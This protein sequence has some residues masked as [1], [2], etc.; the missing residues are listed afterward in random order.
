MRKRKFLTYPLQWHEGM[1]M[2]PQHFQQND[3]L[4]ERLWGYHL[5]HLAPFYWGIHDLKVDPTMLLRSVLR[6]LSFE[7]VMPDGTVLFFPQEVNDTLEISLEDLPKDENGVYEVFLT[8]ADEKESAEGVAMRYKTFEHTVQDLHNENARASISRLRYSLQLHIG[9][10]MPS[11]K[12]GIRIL[13]LLFKNRRFQ[14]LDYTPATLFFKREHPLRLKT[15]DIVE[16]MQEKLFY[17]Y[18][19]IKTLERLANTLPD[20]QSF[21]RFDFMRRHLISSL[22]PLEALLRQENCAPYTL[23]QHLLTLVGHCASCQWG[24]A[25]P[26]VPAYEHD[27]IDASLQP[28]FTFVEE[29]LAGI[30]ENYRVRTFAQEER[31]FCLPIA[32]SYL[33][34]ALIIG[35][36][37][38]VHSEHNQLSQWLKDAVIVSKRFLDTIQSNRVLGAE[39]R[40]IEAAS[41]LHLVPDKGT[42][43]CRVEVDDPFVVADEELYIFNISDTDDTRPLEVLLYV[44][45]DVQEQQDSGH[46]KHTVAPAEDLEDDETQAQKPGIPPETD[47]LERLEEDAVEPS[48][49]EQTDLVV[50]TQPLDQDNED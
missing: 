40:L 44:D 31:L 35:V 19:K 46:K 27:N 9:D 28:L 26:T 25:A 10:K 8:L 47:T 45:E 39:R 6:I 50:E 18:R 48:V 3:I 15:L 34:N 36:K 24:E 42:I 1:F 22:L 23:Y 5:N 33:N 38:S 20:V 43:L 11:G 12:M 13:R 37:G 32:A 16:K 4:R 49:T 17:L 21:L 2:E 29:T 7:V 30:E 14:L 41:H